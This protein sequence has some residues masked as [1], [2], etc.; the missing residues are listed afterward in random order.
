MTTRKHMT[1]HLQGI[2]DA[3]PAH[4]GNPM[5]C[6]EII[7][8][9]HSGYKYSQ[10]QI[11]S[12]L[13]QLVKLHD[14]VSADKNPGSAGYLYVRTSKGDRRANGKANG[15]SNLDRKLRRPKEAPAIRKTEARIR[16][17]AQE[18]QDIK[19]WRKQLKKELLY[20]VLK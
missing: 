12:G 10:N 11:S 2:L 19:M 3:V 15:A 20:L 1:A 9:T 6:T 17:I 5:L 4:G 13:H 16:E 7:K 8:R 18:L 14:L